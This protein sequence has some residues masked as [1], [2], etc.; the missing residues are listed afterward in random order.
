MCHVGC[1]RV[2]PE[3]WGI[4]IVCGIAPVAEQA[5]SPV[6]PRLPA[7]SL[8][9]GPSSL[10]PVPCSVSRALRLQRGLPGWPA[11]IPAQPMGT[12]KGGGRR[13]Q[14]VA[15]LVCSG[16]HFWPRL[17]LGCATGF[18]CGPAAAGGPRPLGPR[19]ATR[20][21][22]PSRP[23]TEVALGS[24]LSLGCRRAFRLTH[25]HCSRWFLAAASELPGVGRFPDGNKVHGL[26]I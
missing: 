22:C 24:C 17:Q 3:P 1:P 16:G 19:I 25:L 12:A 4:R 13:S 14:V 10:F 21:L 26:G 2:F 7:T 11:S 8:A 23:R 9:L 20:S 5:G 6:A 15:P 18:L